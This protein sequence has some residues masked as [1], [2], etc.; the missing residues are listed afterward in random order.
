MAFNYQSVKESTRVQYD[1][2]WKLWCDLLASRGLDPWLSNL[3]GPDQDLIVASLIAEVR[4][5]RRVAHSGIK[6]MRFAVQFFFGA[7]AVDCSF[8]DSPM[9]KRAFKTSGKIKDMP[10]RRK[11]AIGS[12]HAIP[13]T[14]EMINALRPKPWNI[15]N[16]HNIGVYLAAVVALHGLHRVSEVA[17]ETTSSTSGC[18]TLMS[19]D[20][21]VELKD[22]DSEFPSRY[23]KLLD[24]C[25]DSR[26]KVSGVL[27]S[28]HSHKCNDSHT[29][30]RL[31]VPCGP[32]STVD[33]RQLVYDMLWWGARSGMK[34]DELLF[35][36]HVESISRSITRH[37][38]SNFA[39]SIGEYFGLPIEAFATHGFRRG[40]SQMMLWAGFDRKTVNKAGRWVPNSTSSETYF[41][42]GTS[43][44]GAL[45]NPDLVSQN[46]ESL[47][48][49][50][51]NNVRQ[52]VISARVEG[53]TSMGKRKLKRLDE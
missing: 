51:V 21:A 9:V 42:G 12:Q 14:L 20:V 15:S 13:V 7:R 53:L 2:G 41:T 1:R 4:K 32:S 17:V 50:I 33:E 30:D 28:L 8:W 3:T 27:F 36:Y 5:E 10:S 22:D 6:N 48:D 23:V 18:H 35:R 44:C 25:P 46:I 16:I 49:H 38:L 40:G 47:T 37:D 45:S 24:W 39:K 34:S 31:F 43:H 19:D 52:A 29:T 26:W 11:A